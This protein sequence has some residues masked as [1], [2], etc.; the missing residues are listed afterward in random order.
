M[1]ETFKSVIT[2]YKLLTMEF[3]WKGKVVQLVGEPQI[4]ND[5]LLSKQLMNLSKSQS[6]ASL[7][8]LKVVLPKNENNDTTDCI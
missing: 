3:Q 7:Y 2:N 1:A 6:I 4:N 5:L 8:H